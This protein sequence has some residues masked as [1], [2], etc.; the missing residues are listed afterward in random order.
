MVEDKLLWVSQLYHS[1]RKL[2]LLTLCI[3]PYY[4]LPYLALTEYSLYCP[5]LCVSQVIAVETILGSGSGGVY[6]SC[7]FA[8]YLKFPFCSYLS[9]ASCPRYPS[10]FNFSGSSSQFER[11][12]IDLH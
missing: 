11:F 10:T 4:L 9:V 3:V 1:A 8:C 5:T 12:S 2:L 7:I 6:I